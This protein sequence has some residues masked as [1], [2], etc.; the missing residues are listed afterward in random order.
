MALSNSP[1][2]RKELEQF[3]SRSVEDVPD[4]CEIEILVHKK[5]DALSDEALE[6]VTGGVRVPSLGADLFK[7][8][9]FRFSG[10]RLNRVVKYGDRRFA[11][12][13]VLCWC[14]PAAASRYAIYG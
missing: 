12:D 14:E 11:G 7:G 2:D 3:L 8:T 5:T 13:D 9:R 6:G 4:D 1:E 10:G